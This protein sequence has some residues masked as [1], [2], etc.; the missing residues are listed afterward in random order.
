MS[1][2]EFV[3]RRQESTLRRLPAPFLEE[4]DELFH[5][6]L[7]GGGKLRYELC[8]VFR[9]HVPTEQQSIPQ[10]GS[11]SNERVRICEYPQGRDAANQG[12]RTKDKGQ[13]L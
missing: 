1:G 8:Q 12:P 9:F 4:G 2:D 13:A 10:P 11:L 7:L 6:R 5:R 3:D